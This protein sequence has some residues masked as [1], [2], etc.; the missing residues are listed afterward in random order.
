MWS[1]CPL[2][3]TLDD[4][5]FHRYCHVIM[6][7]PGLL[8]RTVGPSIFALAIVCVCRTIDFHQ[9]NR[10]RST[11]P[12][13]QRNNNCQFITNVMTMERVGSSKR[14]TSKSTII[15]RFVRALWRPITFVTLFIQ[16]WHQ[17]IKCQLVFGTCHRYIVI[18]LKSYARVRKIFYK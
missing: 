7:L 14:S 9:I 10:F 8:F 3:A 1:M 5:N 16:H 17:S 6:R 18:V 2:T 4:H 15:Q 11:K 13:R 12:C